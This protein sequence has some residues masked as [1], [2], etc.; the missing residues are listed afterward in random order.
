MGSRGTSP[1]ITSTHK[2]HNVHAHGA[3]MDTSAMRTLQV[4]LQLQKRTRAQRV[5]PAPD[6]GGA[7]EFGEESTHAC[8]N[9]HVRSRNHPRRTSLLHRP[10]A[11]DAGRGGS[12]SSARSKASLALTLYASSGA[13]M[14]SVMSALMY[15]IS[16][17][18]LVVANCAIASPLLFT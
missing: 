6:V 5:M 18:V 14:I 8:R 9:T 17:D 3:R 4:A 11:L 15:V 2:R 7:D 10:S 13:S 12:R 16:C 1:P